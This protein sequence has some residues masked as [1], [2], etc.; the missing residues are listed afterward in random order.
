MPLTKTEAEPHP[1]L[2]FVSAYRFGETP[3]PLNKPATLTLSYIALPSGARP[4]R[5]AIFQREGGAWTYVG[6]SLSQA[7]KS[8]STVVRKLGEFGLFDAPSAAQGSPGALDCQPRAFSPRGGGFK[9]VTDIS[10]GLSKSSP[11][12]VHIY[13]RA[14]RLER[15]LSKD[16]PMSPGL[17]VVSWDGRD[18]G[19]IIVPSGLYI[20]VLMAEGKKLNKT[21]AVTGN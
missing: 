16:A 11:V 5:L 1:S 7:E 12:T 15:V 4:E 17:N 6:G 18:D 19:G 21:V 10:F 20:V 9:G 13:N 8:V 2:T 14:G 3:I